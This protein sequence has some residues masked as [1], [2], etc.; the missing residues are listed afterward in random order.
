MIELKI[1]MASISWTF[2]QV[3][4]RGQLV[5]NRTHVSH[6][7]QAECLGNKLKRDM[8]RFQHMHWIAFSN[9]AR[10]Y[11]LLPDHRSVQRSA[12]PLDDNKLHT[13]THKP[14]QMINR[15]FTTLDFQHVVWMYIYKYFDHS[16][17]VNLRLLHTWASHDL[18]HLR[19]IPNTKITRQR[20]FARRTNFAY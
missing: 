1:N 7:R 18:N 12:A 5:D 8:L 10:H 3:G 11:E 15:R 6:L 20:V 13:R 14:I 16:N 17:N 9:K 19:A 4:L 2:N